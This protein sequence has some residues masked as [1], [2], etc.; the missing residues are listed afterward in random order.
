M[1]KK[2]KE[3]HRGKLDSKTRKEIYRESVNKVR[4][5]LDVLL[6]EA[7]NKKHKEAQS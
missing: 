4:S 5:N 2:H 1:N 3:A 6:K 7:M